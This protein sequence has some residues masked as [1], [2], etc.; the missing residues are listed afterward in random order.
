VAWAEPQMSADPRLTFIDGWLKTHII[1]TIFL[2]MSVT[3]MMQ[4]A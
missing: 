3:P 4:I 2:G 1:K